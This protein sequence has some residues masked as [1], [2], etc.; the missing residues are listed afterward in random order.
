MPA[1]GQ[2]TIA[3]RT[4]PA[5]RAFVLSVTD[6]G[7]GMDAATRAR[8]F[9]PFFTTKGPGRGTGL[10]LATVYGIVKQSGGH[11]WV[12][13]EPQHGTTFKIYFPRVAQAA[14]ST[15]IPLATGG[16]PKGHETILLVE[17]ET[18][19][20]EL[21]TDILRAEGYEVLPAA[22]AR[23][24]LDM[25]AAHAGRIHVLVTDVVMPGT[26]GRE[27]AEQMLVRRQGIAVVYMSGYTDNAV[28]QHGVLGRDA[29]FLQKPFTPDRLTQQV[30]ALLDQKASA[31]R[32]ECEVDRR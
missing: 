31:E 1:G 8:I 16:G 27:L 4:D 17:D 23:Q 21:A 25:S 11:I 20:R 14:E 26:S 22:D 2:V 5:T 9:E 6:T 28:V 10:G 19:V 30:R 15:D 18:A 13:S 7:A 32:V 24:A 29:V 12:Y 3:T